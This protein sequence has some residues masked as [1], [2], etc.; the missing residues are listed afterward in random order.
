[1]KSIRI[2]KSKDSKSRDNLSSNS[3]PS[4]KLRV[5]LIKKR[6][7]PSK[8]SQ[9]IENRGSLRPKTHR[10]SNSH[11]KKGRSKMLT[12]STCMAIGGSHDPGSL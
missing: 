3:S 6:Y 12:R 5:P 8:R 10:N 2:L 1:M 4:I 7:K 9:P 11:T